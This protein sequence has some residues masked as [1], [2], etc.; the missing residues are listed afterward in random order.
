MLPHREIRTLF[1]ARKPGCSCQLQSCRALCFAR[2]CTTNHML[3]LKLL[4]TCRLRHQNDL[5]AHTRIFELESQLGFDL[6]VRRQ[7][8]TPRCALFERDS[9]QKDCTEKKTEIELNLENAD[10][11]SRMCPA[12]RVQQGRQRHGLLS[13]R[14]NNAAGRVGRVAIGGIALSPKG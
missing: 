1:G 10:G 5:A 9:V 8:G 2:E 13:A 14:R 3:V 12:R 7:R 4:P 6:N 11:C